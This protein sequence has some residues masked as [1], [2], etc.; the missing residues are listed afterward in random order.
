MRLV[1]RGRYLRRGR[2]GGRSPVGHR[3]LPA[4]E[5]PARRARSS[6]CSRPTT[7]PTT[8]PGT[9]GWHAPPARPSTSTG[10]PRP[11][12]RTTRSTTGGR[13]AWATVEIEAIH[14]PGHRPEHTSFAVRD[15][16]ER[17]RLGGAHGRL[18][19]HRGRGAAGPRDRAA[20][21]RER[22]LSLPARAAA[23]PR[24]R[25]RR[26]PGAPRRLALRVIG[27]RERGR[28]DDRRR[29]PPQP[30]RW[31]TGARMPSSTPRWPRS[32]SGR[33]TSSTSCP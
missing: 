3:P 19:L 13:C 17:P 4:A 5:P 32:A 26:V 23:E 21:G 1:R 9:A 33:P 27:D 8:C 18:A 30:R 20:G 22:D 14:T 31:P 7:T 6:T 15:A 16:P 12:T 24:R 29:A 28:V 25:G 11:S 10:S 2:G